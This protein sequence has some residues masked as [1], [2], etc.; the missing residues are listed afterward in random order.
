[1]GI[2]ASKGSQPGVGRIGSVSSA[3]DVCRTW[4]PVRK[5][6]LTKRRRWC[7]QRP[8]YTHQHPT[9]TQHRHRKS[10]PCIP[11][12]TPRCNLHKDRPVENYHRTSES[13]NR[14][15]GRGIVV[16]GMQQASRRGTVLIGFT[17]NSQGGQ[18]RRPS[19]LE[20]GQR[21]AGCVFLPVAARCSDSN[22]PFGA[23]GLGPARDRR[24]AI[25]RLLSVGPNPRTAGRRWWGNAWMDEWQGAN[26]WE[27]VRT[28]KVTRDEK[29]KGIILFGLT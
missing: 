4:T 28:C 6:H 20:R 11:P 7:C 5:L 23:V 10:L 1:M 29:W 24:G 26:E 3:V 2:N 17:V 18:C 21:A 13:V 8:W 9:K 12:S 15:S 16:I 27:Y 19:C 25:F 22:L 14:A